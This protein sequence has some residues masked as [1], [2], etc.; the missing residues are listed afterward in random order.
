MISIYTEGRLNNYIELDASNHSYVCV[1][2][3]RKP[4]AN[5]NEIWHETW[6]RWGMIFQKKKKKKNL[7]LQ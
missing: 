1:A 6:N 2:G 3:L 7:E 4:W 5:W